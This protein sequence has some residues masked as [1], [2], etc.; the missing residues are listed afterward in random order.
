[1]KV[2]EQYREYARD[3]R[4]MASTAKD[5]EKAALLQI[6]AAWETLA[7]QRETQINIGVDPTNEPRPPMTN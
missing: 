1:M 6:A 5:A 3:C 2:V 7:T 4:R